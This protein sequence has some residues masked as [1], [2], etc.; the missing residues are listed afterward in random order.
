M[1][2]Y[3]IAL[4]LIA[5][6]S[7]RAYSQTGDDAT[8]LEQR[9]W[10]QTRKAAV[11]E[12]ITTWA[13]STSEKG[14][15]FFV[16]DRILLT[17][18]HLVSPKS[19]PDS[20][21]RYDVASINISFQ[22]APAVT[23]VPYDP[24]NVSLHD[25]LDLAALDIATT[26]SPRSKLPLGWPPNATQGDFVSFYGFGFGESATARHGVIDL[27]DTNQG[28]I[29]AQVDGG[30]GWSGAPVVN[31]FGNVIAVDSE[32]AGGTE[33]FIPLDRAMP[34]LQTFRVYLPAPGAE[35]KPAWNQVSDGKSVAHLTGTVLVRD[36]SGSA[37]A[38]RS[39]EAVVPIPS[40]AKEIVGPEEPTP[41]DGDGNFATNLELKSNDN[42]T[43]LIGA[44][45]APDLLLP[46]NEGTYISI[47]KPAKIQP[48]VVSLEEP[49]EV[50]ERER[51]IANLLAQDAWP[52]REQIFAA[53][54]SCFSQKGALP[55]VY[56]S[57][58]DNNTDKLDSE[59]LPIAQLDN[60]FASALA[61]TR[62]A[63]GPDKKF[64]RAR[65]LG[66]FR[67]QIG[68]PCRAVIAEHDSLAND[69]F[70]AQ[71][72]AISEFASWV[73][74]CMGRREDL[75]QA[76]PGVGESPDWAA[77]EVVSTLLYHNPRSLPRVYND[78]TLSAIL[79]I[80]ETYGGESASSVVAGESIASKPSRLG[81]W[82]WFFEQYAGPR[83][84]LNMTH[85]TPQEISTSLKRLR[86]LLNAGKCI[87]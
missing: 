8:K 21:T 58:R 57:C 80:F 38:A 13:D 75:A 28:F 76:V 66:Q 18:K 17:A 34:W 53:L 22:T 52:L 84:N 86:V 4:S 25:T 40:D 65:F 85:D 41:T 67:N 19:T 29:R 9:I 16:S 68:L 12:I 46:P 11:V 10:D 35:P 51:Y 31:R 50:W 3:L 23:T 61:Y 37:R 69:S 43:L 72:D 74:A 5:F 63:D 42:P 54:P 26:V 82:T 60:M 1:R 14:T 49:L 27:P 77:N 36:A 6:V 15:G 81:Y 44:V 71:P 30:K 59:Q 87:H 20:P 55:S 33:Y 48:G 64:Q 62:D 70:S 56:A 83:C 78:Q 45:E 24:K 47:P 7:Q 39:N 32:G 73:V 2:G 79:T